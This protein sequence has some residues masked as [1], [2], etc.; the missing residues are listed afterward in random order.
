MRDIMNTKEAAAYLR[1]KERKIYE[2]VGD[3]AIPCSKVGG[4]WIFPRSLI[5]RWIL[6]NAQGPVAEASLD[7]PPVIAGSHDPLLEWAVSE[8]ACDLAVM[9]QGSLSGINRFAGRQA[10]IAGTHILDADSGEYNIPAVQQVMPLAD[11][12]LVEWAQREQGLIVS[13]EYASRVTSLRDVAT[14]ELR[15]IG[16][17]TGA[18]SQI[19]LNILLH[20]ERIDSDSLRQLEHPARTES[21]VAASII[22][23]HADV[24]LG[25][26]AVA[27]HYNLGFVPMQRERYD[28][29]MTRRDFCA[30]PAQAL[31]CLTRDPRFTRRAAEI[32]GYDVSNSGAIVFNGP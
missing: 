8:S 18:G 17:Q 28:L 10:T 27:R 21:D 16:R 31:L 11:L 2:L 29:L 4:K 9:F 25:V 1:I 24:G 5:D 13:R 19:L 26:A 14:G 7:R 3:K 32:G 6:E 12:V 15:F 20:R 23:G 30:K 22:N